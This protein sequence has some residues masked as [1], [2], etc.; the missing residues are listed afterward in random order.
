MLGRS[1][2]NALLG[3]IYA[4]AASDLVA[5]Y[6]RQLRKPG[7]AADEDVKALEHW[8]KTNAYGGL[9]DPSYVFRR[10]KELARTGKL[11]KIFKY[12]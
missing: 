1:E 12:H 6:R 11:V 10:C 7:P 9:N 5:A 3:A 8:F 2:V 4:Q